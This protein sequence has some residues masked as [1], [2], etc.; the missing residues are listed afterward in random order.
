MVPASVHA[1]LVVLFVALLRWLADTVG[2][3]IEESTLEQIA[4]FVV[5][6]IL[7]LGGLS[8]FRRAATRP[9]AVG[10]FDDYKPPFT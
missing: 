6:Y 9:N 7:S 3:N 2:L 4:T 10:V 8:L 1:A 5:A